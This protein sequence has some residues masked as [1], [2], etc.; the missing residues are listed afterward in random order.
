M[1]QE[2]R[3]VAMYQGQFSEG[4]ALLETDDLI[5]RGD[6]RLKIPLPAISS[7]IAQ[8]GEL[9]VAFGGETAAFVLG[10]QAARWK[11]RIENPPTLL[12]KL[13]VKPGHLVS[14]VGLDNPPFAVQL[15]ARGVRLVEDTAAAGSDHIFLGVES[16]ADLQRLAALRNYLAPAGGVWV[17]APKGRQHVREADVL[18]AGKPAGLVDVKVARFSE[19]HTAHRFVIPLSQR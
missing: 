19:T 2:Q 13:G 8:D 5:F 6:F 7:V 3:C 11:E 15:R 14:V 16:V 18:A 1:G 9:H 12:D 17:V 10:Q 4:K